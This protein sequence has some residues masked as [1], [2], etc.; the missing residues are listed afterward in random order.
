MRIRIIENKRVVEQVKNY[1]KTISN[2]IKFKTPNA[3]TMAGISENTPF[4]IRIG[5]RGVNTLKLTN[6]KLNNITKSTN[7]NLSV[8]KEIDSQTIENKTSINVKYVSISYKL[9]YIDPMIYDDMIALREFLTSVATQYSININIPWRKIVRDQSYLMARD[10]NDVKKYCFDLFTQL[11][12]KY[13]SVFKKDPAEFNKLP[14]I[15]AGE[16]RVVAINA[17]GKPQVDRRGKTYFSEWDDLIDL[18]KAHTT[19][20]GSPSIG[21]DPV[22]PELIPYCINGFEIND[23]QVLNN[24]STVTITETSRAEFIISSPVAINSVLVKLAG[25]NGQSVTASKTGNN[26]NL[27]Y[28]QAH[29]KCNK[30]GEDNW[31]VTITNKNGDKLT[32]SLKTK[33]TVPVNEQIKPSTTVL[34]KSLRVNEIERLD[35]SDVFSVANTGAFF[36]CT[37]YSTIKVSKV[38]VVSKGRNN[39]TINLTPITSY[40]NEYYFKTVVPN[41]NDGDDTWTV[42]ATLS[43][44]KTLTKT[45]KI[46]SNN[47][48]LPIGNVTVSEFKVNQMNAHYANHVMVLNKKAAD[49]YLAVNT[50]WPIAKIVVKVTGDNPKSFVRTGLTTYNGKCYYSETINLNYGQDKWLFT[51][52]DQQGNCVSQALDTLVDPD[53]I[54]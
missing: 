28:F 29:V 21:G 14:T 8:S 12:K 32:T 7:V 2:S 53:Y 1:D 44:G 25:T 43:D 19:G 33:V 31:T 49:I 27:Y 16:A 47:V 15:K 11:K 24:K 6:M 36:E 20:I 5:T 23:K 9:G 37:L 22:L 48:P 46:R 38:S 34:F 30:S 17:S 26:G 45:T 41:P 10:F 42:T 52:Y 35:K 50:T 4:T 54:H 40:N 13:P 51:I 18:I 39:H 3:A